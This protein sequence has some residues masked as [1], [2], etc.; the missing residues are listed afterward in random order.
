MQELSI[1]EADVSTGQASP[2][3]PTKPR[4]R[5]S[6]PE[7]RKP[8]LQVREL[9]ASLAGDMGD[10]E[11]VV[12]GAEAGVE[13]DSRRT[14]RRIGLNYKNTADMILVQAVF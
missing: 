14:P 12:L 5:T 9:L 13:Q 8:L 3:A 11:G 1:V 7:R 4:V 10:G 2:V 6:R